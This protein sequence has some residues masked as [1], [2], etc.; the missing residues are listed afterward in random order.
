LFDRGLTLM[1][2][3]KFAEACEQ[4]EQSQAIE[5][6]IGTMLYLADCYEHLG[7]TA[8]AWALFREASSAARAEGQSERAQQGASRAALLEPK[9]SKLS[10]SVAAENKLSGLVVLVNGVNLVSGVWGVPVP[11]DPGESHIQARAPGYIEW[12]TVQ[13]VPPSG[14]VNVVVPMLQRDFATASVAEA[15]APAPQ[16]GSQPSAAATAA[17][18]SDTG[19]AAQRTVSIVVGATGVVALGVGT[20]F[21]LRA[22][23]KDSDADELCEVSA[24][25]CSSP[26][27]VEL[28]E[29]AN[30]AATV[31]NVFVFGG[32]ALLVTGVVMY[33]TAPSEKAPALAFGGDAT[34]A[35]MTLRGEF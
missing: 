2:E 22:L 25:G 14:S 3:G 4:L 9:L 26:D 30:S 7:R 20:Y 31:S 32:A 1:R 29:Q 15:P 18:D 13:A 24:P 12:A 5:V 34:G 27:G 10:V 11:V 16:A 17:V 21:G 6:G 35:H 8:S 19:W 28:A 33:L 23:S